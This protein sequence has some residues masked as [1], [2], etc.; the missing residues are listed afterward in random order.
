MIFIKYIHINSFSPES[1]YENDGDV[2]F[3]RSLLKIVNTK[4][5]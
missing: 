2:T 4:V 3:Y 5:Q 1:K